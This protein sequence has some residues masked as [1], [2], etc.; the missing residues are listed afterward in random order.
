[1]AFPMLREHSPLFN[2]LGRS[3]ATTSALLSNT[4]ES[5]A[6]LRIPV[7][8][9]IAIIIIC[10]LPI[11]LNIFGVSFA[12]NPIPLDAEFVMLLTPQELTER[13]HGALVGSYT[14]TILEWSAFCTAIFT[15][16]LAFAHFK[17]KQDAIT[18]ILGIALLCA[19]LM[20]AFHT[21]AADRLIEA[22]ADNRNLIP[23]TWALCR[24]FNALISIIGVSIFLVSDVGQ[25]RWKR[26]SM[27]VVS[28][29]SLFILLAYFTIQ[30]CANSAHLPQ[31]T[32]PDAFFTRPWDVFPLILFIF[33]G[34]WLY[35]KFHRK[36]PSLFSHALVVSAIPNIVT[37]VHMAFGSSA[38]FDNHFNIAHFLKIIAY[39]VPL[40]GLVLDYIHTH[41]ALE[42]RNLDFSLEIK[43]RKQ[44]EQALQKTL[45]DLKDTQVQLIQ[46]EKMSGLGQM[47]SGVAHE[48]N[49]PVSFIH[50]NLTHLEN[51]IADLLEITRLYQQTYPHPPENIQTTIDEI[52]LDFLQNDT[53]KILDSMK[54]GTG[55]IRDIVKSL[56]TFSRL[57]EADSKLA[58]IHE[59]LESTLMIL[60]N[61]LRPTSDRPCSLEVVRD[62]GHNVPLVECYPGQ[63]NQ[64][65]MNI[66]G[67]SLD[68]ID[69]TY[70]NK[71]KIREVRNNEALDKSHLSKE[72]PKK[73]TLKTA[74]TKDKEQVIISIQDNGIGMAE[75]TLNK[76]FD[77]FF[78][79]KAVGQGTGLGLSISH[80]I[81]TEYHR[82]Q[83]TCTSVLNKGT[84]FH[85]QIPIRCGLT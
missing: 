81:I 74:L 31:T 1:M 16:I 77:P 70:L 24:M 29:S 72:T 79:T 83:L 58:D 13:M 66:L 52:D 84:T 55:R 45:N 42:E 76:I 34:G 32:F 19:G 9:T 30:I 43:E 36:Y 35:P 23:F 28:V 57:D 82:G 44:T 11:V 21:L 2:R 49:N 18:P 80:Q 47:V 10:V 46:T 65:F 6:P 56:R 61:R 39:L 67:N 53:P 5:V 37:Q 71:S 4:A 14:H 3:Q 63:L 68:A 27:F 59:G 41:Q 26:S 64:V 73:I 12:S 50:G 78:T 33:S 20:D 75:A 17:I 22:V 38:L 15:V 25:T 51:Y 62:Y 54:L 85:I 7:A 40:A 48:I 69:A 60:Q 8:L